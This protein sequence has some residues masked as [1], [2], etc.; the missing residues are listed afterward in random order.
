MPGRVSV[1]PL[2]AFPPASRIAI[3]TLRLCIVRDGNGVAAISTTCTHLGCI[4]GPVDAGF[5]CPCHGSRFDRNGVVIGGPAPASLQWYAL[6]LAPD[7][8]LEV[9]TSVEVEPGTYLT[10]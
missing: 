2:A 7:G 3:D 5:A 8:G 6:R 4:A 1:G 9:D 10:V